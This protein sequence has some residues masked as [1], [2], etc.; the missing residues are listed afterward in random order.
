MH[1]VKAM[2]KEGWEATYVPVDSEGIIIL[3][4]LKKA[5]RGDTV[6]VTCMFANNEIGTIQPIEEIGRICR[7]KG[8]LFHTD[9]V[10]AVGHL[11][12]DVNKMNIDLLS[13]SAHKFGGAQGHRRALCGKR[14]KK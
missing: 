3:D 8:V 11:T 13:L 2:E 1:T 7:E 4:E 14:H 10:Q 6:L 12:I 9:A 5:I